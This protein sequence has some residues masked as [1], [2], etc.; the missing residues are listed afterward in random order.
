MS[1]PATLARMLVVGLAL[2]CTAPVS[3]ILPTATPPAT[4]RA[5]VTAAPTPPLSRLRAIEAQYGRTLPPGVFE[6]YNGLVDR[7]N[8]LLVPYRADLA[9]HNAAVDER[10]TLATSRRSLPC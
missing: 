9:A 4:S 3:T 8:A 6:E 2:S 7:Y 5:A 1:G 10:N